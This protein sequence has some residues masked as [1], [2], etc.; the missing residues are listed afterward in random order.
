MRSPLFAQSAV[1][2]DALRFSAR[3]AS[4]KI[5]VGENGVAKA[6]G[7]ESALS[8]MQVNRKIPSTMG[9]F[10]DSCEKG[11]IHVYAKRKKS[12]FFY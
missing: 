10:T 12:C 2:K 7:T 4:D 3:D 1:I 8:D 6:A 11:K 5:G 9:I